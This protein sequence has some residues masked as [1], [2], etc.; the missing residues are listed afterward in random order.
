MSR[1]RY[2]PFFIGGMIAI[3]LA[4]SSV[5]F[6]LFFGDAVVPLPPL[7]LETKTPPAM[8]K[9]L[10]G[11]V[12]LAIAQC[13]ERKCEQGMTTLTRAKH[14][15]SEFEFDEN[16]AESVSYLNFLIARCCFK[17]EKYEEALK[18]V[19]L[20]YKQF[21]APANVNM[22]VRVLTLLERDAQTL[23]MR[24]FY[25]RKLAFYSSEQARLN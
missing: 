12:E 20:S 11:D 3:L 8:P 4:T 18:Y 23:N 15:L 22:L 17:D 9:S 21:N 24:D 10:V 1:S 7:S 16:F 6:L 13:N 2:S 5:M 14:K 25:S 19:E